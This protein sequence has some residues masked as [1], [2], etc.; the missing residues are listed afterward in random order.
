MTVTTEPD[1]ESTEF[2]A[3]TKPKKTSKSNKSAES[4]KPAR[5]IELHEL[6]TLM[7][8][9]AVLSV[10]FEGT[11]GGFFMRIR[12]NGGDRMLHERRGPLRVFKLAQSALGLAKRLGLDNCKFAKVQQWQPDEAALF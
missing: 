11:S 6:Q 2:S 7:E 9:G 12:T 4:D 1:D 10:V 5:P 8:A 3:G